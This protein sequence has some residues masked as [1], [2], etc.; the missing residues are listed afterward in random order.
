MFR[1][2]SIVLTASFAAIG[3]AMPIIIA[4]AHAACGQWLPSFDH[5]VVWVPGQEFAILWDPAT[6]PTDDCALSPSVQNADAATGQGSPWGV[7][8]GDGNGLDPS[9]G[10]FTFTVPT[11]PGPGQYYL[12]ITEVD[13]SEDFF[14]CYRPGTCYYVVINLCRHDAQ[15]EEPRCWSLAVANLSSVVVVLPRSAWPR[16]RCASCSSPTHLR[17]FSASTQ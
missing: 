5:S 15:H 1:L 10:S 13:Q 14:P 12:Q 4:R 2:S 17:A 6:A 11:P 8:L 9:S 7:Y 3:T 16:P